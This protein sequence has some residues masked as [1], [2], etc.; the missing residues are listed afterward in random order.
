MGYPEDILTGIAKITGSK[1]GYKVSNVLSQGDLDKALDKGPVV[2]AVAWN[3]GG[4]HAIT[5]HGKSSGKYQVHDPW[6][7]NPDSDL[8][9]DKLSNYLNEGKWTQTVHSGSS[10][11]SRRRRRRKSS[12]AEQDEVAT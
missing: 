9:Y 6:P 4:G 1:N 11:D 7:S 10:S 2:V 8:S 3:G 5:V 12:S